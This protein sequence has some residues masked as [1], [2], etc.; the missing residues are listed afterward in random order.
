M[1]GVTPI[2]RPPIQSGDSFTYEFKA[3]PAGTHWYHSHTGLQYSEGLQGPLVIES[4]MNDYK[5]DREQ[6]L[7]IGDFF[8]ESS[9]GI[10][11]KIKSGYRR[12][13]TRL[14]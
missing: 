3:E 5:Y 10:Y 6:V 7:M 4:K 2:S 8:E 13:E 9:N 14:R 11:E 12:A 1:D